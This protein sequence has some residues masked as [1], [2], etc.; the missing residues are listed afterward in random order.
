VDARIAPR[1]DAPERRRDAW[2]RRHNH[3]H[4]GV[5]LRARRPLGSKCARTRPAAQQGTT[6]L[7]EQIFI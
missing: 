6:W 7:S 4:V 5:R 1:A 3:R 2:R